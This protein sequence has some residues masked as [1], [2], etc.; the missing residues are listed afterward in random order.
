MSTLTSHD[1]QTQVAPE[2]LAVRRQTAATATA[3]KGSPKRLWE[4]GMVSGAVIFS[5]VTLMMA[6][7]IYVKLVQW[8]TPRPEGEASAAIAGVPVASGPV[9]PAAKLR[10]KALFA[11]GCNACHGDDARGRP[12]LGKDLVHSPFVKSQ[13]DVQMVG[14][15]K[16]GRDV[17]DPLNTTKIPMP[18]KGGNP[19]LNDNQLKDLVA[20][21]R[22]LQG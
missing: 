1:L 19:A 8:H 9:D 17:S 12:G 2:R 6:P 22:G 14:F 5:V 21:L 11:Q 16:K 10:G 13:G 15:L 7:T 20:Y 4:I 3:G 18:P